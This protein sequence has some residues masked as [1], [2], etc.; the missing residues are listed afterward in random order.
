MDIVHK[1]RKRVCGYEGTVSSADLEKPIFLCPVNLPDSSSHL[2]CHAL[3]LTELPVPSVPAA[4]LT[5]QD[6]TAPTSLAPNNNTSDNE[7]SKSQNPR[8]DGG[9]LK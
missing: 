2:I 7:R 4:A 1:L 6:P 8:K 5:G 3:S 9:L